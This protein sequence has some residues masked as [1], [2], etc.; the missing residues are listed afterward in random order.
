M[1]ATARID[2][3]GSERPKGYGR[4]QEN[5]RRARE[6]LTRTARC[7]GS[8]S[9]NA[10]FPTAS[11]AA[12]FL[13]RGI[14]KGKENVYKPNNTLLSFPTF[15]P[16]AFLGFHKLFRCLPTLFLFLRLPTNVCKRA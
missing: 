14:G 13:L 16:R 6:V 12:S 8:S 4:V 5:E 9:L 11:S 2:E 15:G 3:R 10:A 1:R 7:Q